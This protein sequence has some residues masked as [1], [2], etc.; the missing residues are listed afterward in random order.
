MWGYLSKWGWIPPIPMHRTN[1]ATQTPNSAYTRQCG[2]CKSTP[3]HWGH[4]TLTKLRSYL[5]CPGLLRVQWIQMNLTGHCIKVVTLL[6]GSWCTQVTII[7]NK[8]PN[9]Q[10]G[11]IHY[12]I[13]YY[14]QFSWK[15]NF[16]AARVKKGVE[17]CLITK[18]LYHRVPITHDK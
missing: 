10:L 5:F 14:H 9:E 4:V 16:T 11:I 15:N 3:S 7:Y 6:R 1:P 2:Q 17:L 12:N 13:I 18:L 8:I